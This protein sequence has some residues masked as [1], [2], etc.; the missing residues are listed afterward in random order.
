MNTS[1]AHL[2]ELRRNALLT[3]LRQADV[4]LRTCIHQLE[5]VALR[6]AHLERALAHLREAGIAVDEQTKIRS[7][8]ELA[9]HLARIEQ[10]QSDLRT[11]QPVSEHTT[12]STHA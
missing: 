3:E 12:H 5:V 2:L 9:D 8:Q 10:I 7:V 6:H 11:R 1:E 4:R